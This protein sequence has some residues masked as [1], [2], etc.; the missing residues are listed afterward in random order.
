MKLIMK[1]TIHP[2][3]G[4]LWSWNRRLSFEFLSSFFKSSQIYNLLNICFYNCQ[5]V[6]CL[7]IQI[8]NSPKVEILF[9][10]M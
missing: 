5:F 4:F 10:I 9:I 8:I 1:G 2:E 7:P 6:I 3:D